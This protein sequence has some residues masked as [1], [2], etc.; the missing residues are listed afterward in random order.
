MIGWQRS[1]GCCDPLTRVMPY[2]RGVRRACVVMLVLVAAAPAQAGGLAI[3]G[4]SPRAIGRAGAGTVSDDGAGALL[5]NPAALARRDT[6]RMQVGVALAED[7]TEWL[8]DD[9][10]A[11]IARDQA[12]SQLLPVAAVAGSIAGWT[13]AA[14]VMTAGVTER[15]LRDPTDVPRPGDQ[16]ALFGYRY[17]GIAGAVRRDTATI[18]IARR[19]GDAVA[20][21]A[22]FGLSRIEVRETRRIWAGFTGIT[23]VGDPSRD[24]QLALAGTDDVVPSATAGILLAPPDQPLEL[25]ASV[26]WTARTIADGDV[27]A[28]GSTGGTSVRERS[29][30]AQ[31]AFR[32]PVAVRAAARYLGEHVV[33]EVGGDLWLAPE[34]ARTAT[35]MVDGITV[36]DPST[37]TVDLTAVPS[38]ISQRT[39]GALRAAVDV[40]LIP[41]FLWGTAGYAYTVGGTTERRLSPTLGAL[42][43]HTFALGIEGSSGGFTYTLGWSRTQAIQKRGGEDFSLDNPFGAGT[44]PIAPGRYDGSA[45]QLGV[46]LDVEL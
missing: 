44:A 2:S 7:A 34:S 12:G 11:P 14:G 16:G 37:V 19:L 28:T 17:A 5:L 8:S 27:D 29:P 45:D 20:L 1:A 35:W 23:P 4:G 25:G 31:I 24:V 32:H 18:A 6:T 13:L 33:V 40:E 38:R 10:A 30:R 15:V 21:G 46:L 3:V 36:V 9:A 39:H 41:G 43:G 22:S 26:A 42:D